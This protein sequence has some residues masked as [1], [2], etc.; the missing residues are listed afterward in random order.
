MK[1]D[2]LYRAHRGDNSW[3]SL[4]QWCEKN[5][6]HGGNYEPTWRPEYPFIYFA[7]EKEY[8]LFVLRWS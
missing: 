5:L 2:N 7:D 4:I 8:M 6:Y 1:L 3:Y